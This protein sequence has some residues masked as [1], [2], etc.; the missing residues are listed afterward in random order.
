MTYPE[1]NDD[2][3]TKLR[4]GLLREKGGD[5]QRELL[6]A[7]R[8]NQNF[9]D[10]IEHRIGLH[11]GDEKFELWSDQ[12]S[13]HEYKDPPV[14]IEKTLFLKWREVTPAQASRES[15]WGHVT[16]EHIKQGL[17]QSS[18]LAAN[19]GN[20]PGGLER[21]DKAL[22]GNDQETIDSVVRTILRR[23]GGLPEPRGRRSV[24]VDCPFGRA[25]WRGYVAQQVCRETRAELGKV[26]ATLRKTQTYWEKLIDRIVSR[27]S[28]LGDTKVL[29]AL[30][31]ALSELVDDQNNERIFVSDA[32]VN[33]SRRIGIRAAWQELAVFSMDDLKQ[34]M[35]RDFL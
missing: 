17:I 13:E 19:G 2:A 1:L 34:V 20:L 30:I 26:R 7:T 28:V 3:Y 35:E 9:T 23:L 22:G 4:K 32:L 18:F 24:Y 10:W 25:W 16:I 5:L 14:A 6:T 11:G 15:F 12:L 21:I 29:S 8:D 27:N 33:I 31:W